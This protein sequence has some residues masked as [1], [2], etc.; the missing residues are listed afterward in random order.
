MTKHAKGPRM[1]LY[2]RLAATF[3]IRSLFFR[4]ALA[5]GGA[6]LIVAVLLSSIYYQ[7]LMQ[8]GVENATTRQE[9]TLHLFSGQIV[10]DINRNV[11]RR[12]E[13]A[14][15][16][17][18][19][20]IGD[21]FVY[22][23]VH[24]KDGGLMVAL[25]DEDGLPA[26]FLEPHFATIR[27]TMQ[28][29]TLPDLQ[30][31]VSPAIQPNGNLAGFIL[32]V[33]DQAAI[34][35]PIVKLALAAVGVLTGVFLVWTTL[36]ILMMRRMVG[37]P[38][39]SISG[40]LSDLEAGHYDVA[41]HDFGHL[42][43]MK[44][45][46]QHF[47]AL[48]HALADAAKMQEEQRIDNAAKSAAI[49][50]L[51]GGLAALADRDLASH[52][53]QPFAGQFEILRENFNTAQHVMGTTLHSIS[54]VCSSVD[55]EVGQLVSAA[56]D[57]STRADHQARTLSD[58]L[59]SLSEAATHTETAVDRARGVRTTVMST[60]ETVKNSGDIVVSAVAAMSEIETSSAEVQKIIGVIEDIAFQTNLLALNAAVEASRAGE[61]GRG[62]AVVATEIQNLSNRTT[63]AAR[64]IHG[65]I[66]NSVKQMKN[67]ANLVRDVGTSLEQAIG[68]VRTVDQDVSALVE[69]FVGY[70]QTLGGIKEGAASLDQA[71]KQ[72]AAMAENIKASTDQLHAR[73]D[74]LRGYVTLFS[75]PDETGGDSQR[76]WVA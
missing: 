35:A 51:S 39:R 55:D 43:Q 28:P 66:S 76:A 50:E 62:F 40:A 4:I 61:A 24:N 19:E 1:S 13:I 25:G 52:I 44:S 18:I 56:S 7:Q 45:I 58:I 54:S 2:Q 48:E 72:S 60:N 38:L 59:A 37:R 11:T 70:S 31:V 3:D 21:V 30:L 32:M 71:T 49:E 42:T 16:A 57:L 15:T 74:D 75:L 5:L 29:V 64:E 65:L 68:G 27:E 46:Q 41:R 26:G 17:L 69:T 22:G 10:Q 63:D 14:F 12:I 6:G 73:S 33:W 67:G 34:Q 23:A 8:K 20:R 36:V 47:H 9:E 53:A